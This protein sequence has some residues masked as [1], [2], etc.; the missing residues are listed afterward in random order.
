MYG[1]NTAFSCQDENLTLKVVVI[2]HSRSCR[3]T[4][5]PAG[6]ALLWQ[7]HADSDWSDLTETK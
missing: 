3:Y 1:V 4:S 5:S 7:S 2:H 6:A